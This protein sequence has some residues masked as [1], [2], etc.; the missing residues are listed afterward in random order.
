MIFSMVAKKIKAKKTIY[1]ELKKAL[2]NQGFSSLLYFF[3]FRITWLF[4]IACTLI[5]IFS[6]KLGITDTTVLNTCVGCA[7]AELGLHT[8]LIIWKTKAENVVR[9]SKENNI[10]ISEINNITQ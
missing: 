8:G 2:L 9:M 7:F 6:S 4:V 10:E 5:T 1:K 3:N